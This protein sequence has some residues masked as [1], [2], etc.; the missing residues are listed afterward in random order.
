MFSR[1]P[2]ELVIQALS[3]FMAPHEV[4]P[5]EELAALA[6]CRVRE[7]TGRNDYTPQDIRSAI[8]S[9]YTKAWFKTM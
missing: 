9:I 8:G 6:H 5:L 7:F 4:R 1:N 2:E 3:P